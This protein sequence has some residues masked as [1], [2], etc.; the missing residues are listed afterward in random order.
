MAREREGEGEM[1]REGRF[2]GREGAVQG[3]ILPFIYVPFLPLQNSFPII[4]TIKRCIASGPHDSCPASCLSSFASPCCFFFFFLPMFTAYLPRLARI[5][6]YLYYTL[7]LVH[8]LS[9]A[10]EKTKGGIS[11]EQEFRAHPVSTPYKH[12]IPL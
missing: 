8:Y 12:L 9:S 7:P 2:G 1:A 10:F 3:E 5:S 11:K 6:F 4:A